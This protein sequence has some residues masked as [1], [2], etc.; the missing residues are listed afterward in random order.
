MLDPKL[1]STLEKR[2]VEA[3]D[4]SE[5]AARI[6]LESLAVH[7][8]EAYAN[9]SE[10]EK[11]L[12]RALRAKARLLGTRPEDDLSPL[13]EE[14]AYVRWHRFLFARFLA[15]NELLM[16]PEYGV[17]VSMSDCAELAPEEGDAD[18]WATASRYAQRM[19]PAV[20]RPGDP[21]LSVTFFPEGRRAMILAM[22]GIPKPAFSS[23]DGL[24]WSYQFWQTKAKKEV[25]ASGRK[26]GGRD[27]PPV[28]QLFTEDYMVK[29]LLHNT[30][31]AWWAAKH[32]DSSINDDLTYL[33]RLGEDEP[34]GEIHREPE[35]KLDGGAGVEGGEA[36]AAGGFEGWP[37]RAAELRFLD[38][39]CGSGH[40]LVAAAELLARMRS[41]EEGLSE[42]GAYGAV[43]RDNLFGLEIDRRCTEL[44]AFALALEAWKRGG[45]REL[46]LPNVA[47]SGIPA[48]GSAEEWTRLA[49][50]DARLEET[51]RRLRGL[52]LDAPHLGS[53]I[54]PASVAGRPEQGELDAADFSEA[55]G[56]LERALSRERN[57]D[58]PAAAIF[59]EAAR[60]VARAAGILTG[61]YHLVAT[62]VPYLARGKQSDTLKN[63]LESR[64]VRSKADLATAFVERCRDF[65]EKGG[66]YALVTPQNWLFLGTYKKLREHLLKTQSWRLVAR[67]GSGAFETIGGEVVNVALLAATNAPPAGDHPMSGLDVSRHKT[68]TGKDE[69]LRA[70]EISVLEQSGQLENPDARITLEP[71]ST[72][73][74]LENFTSYH[75]GICSGDYM[76]FGRCFWELPYITRDWKFQQSTVRATAEYGGLEHVFY[77]QNGS[78]EFYSFVCERL[79][80]SGVSAWIRGDRAWN[81]RGVAV[82]ATGALLVSLYTGELF[83]DNT[84][85]ITPQDGAIVKCCGLGSD[86][87]A[88]FSSFLST[89]SPITNL[90]PA[91]TSGTSR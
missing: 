59:G 36:P 19:L 79:G 38:P 8:R 83:D 76:R 22:E 9:L 3:R 43:L 25:N 53:L 37:E 81:N 90:A 20:F 30:L 48:G 17:P 29:F 15:E 67:L 34:E 27:L 89:S 13:V 66:T 91:R 11:A 62:N 44:A 75:N 14:L 54:H 47:C 73:P 41:E 46:P 87:A 72:L 1:R 70:E 60:G 55:A 6:A 80:E 35:W 69:A 16:H 61:K 56:L 74:L 68:P 88:T 42:A 18:G 58:D 64:H 5:A 7:E 32:P 31:G 63:H 51:L 52:F 40:F 77:W 45:Y 26:I 65:C 57:G 23:D 49:R 21:L 78:G 28:T 86:H 82:S 39:C 24:G 71:S 84:M 2:I 4:A 85:V 50:G 12:R 10:E 33:R